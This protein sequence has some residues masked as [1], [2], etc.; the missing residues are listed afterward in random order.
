MIHS[1]QESE[2]DAKKKTEIIN[3]IKA[4]LDEIGL[5]ESLPVI[6]TLGT[7]LNFIFGR[8]LT[9]LHVN[10]TKLQQVI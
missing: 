2:G 3:N 5:D 9:G 7:I 8:I 6:R 1:L 10:E 4:I